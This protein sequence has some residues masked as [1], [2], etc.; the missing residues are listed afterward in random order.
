MHCLRTE[1]FFGKRHRFTLGGFRSH[2]GTC[3]AGAVQQR[4]AL[5]SAIGPIR[6]HQNSALIMRCRK[7]YQNQNHNKS[8]KTTPWCL[9]SP[10]LGACKFSVLPS[11]PQRGA[12][13]RWL[14]SLAT[15]AQLGPSGLQLGFEQSEV[16][17]INPTVT[18]NVAQNRASQ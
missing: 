9:V 8:Y 3:W 6:V 7:Q 13:A 16:L 18:G 17:L 4:Q 2:C 1:R 10:F 15:P 5:S 12:S 11:L 14:S